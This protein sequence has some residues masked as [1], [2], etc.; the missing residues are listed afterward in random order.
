MSRCNFPI[1]IG[2]RITFASRRIFTKKV[3]TLNGTLFGNDISDDS[4]W[5]DFVFLSTISQSCLKNFW[6]CL[7]TSCGGSTSSNFFENTFFLRLQVS[8]FLIIC[9]ANMVKFNDSLV[10]MYFMQKCNRKQPIVNFDLFQNYFL[11][12]LVFWKILRDTCGEHRKRPEISS[13]RRKVEVSC[14]AKHIIV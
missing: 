4:R 2:S 10:K 8:S 6:D 9:I 11:F 1:F 5:K 14:I 12:H 13:V 7:L 3:E